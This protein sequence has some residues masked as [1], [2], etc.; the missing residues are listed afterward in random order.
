MLNL[1]SESMMT[2]E[3][4]I[5]ALE[6]EMRILKEEKDTQELEIRHL[7]LVSSN[8]NSQRSLHSIKGNTGK[9]KGSNTGSGNN[10]TM[11]FN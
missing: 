7:K 8:I 9:G 10:S 11:K 6:S 4:K 1:S 3:N 5:R 2:Y